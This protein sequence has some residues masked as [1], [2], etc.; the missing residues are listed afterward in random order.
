MAKLG[1][2]T[3]GGLSKY[4]SGTVGELEIS[5]KS[6][7]K[8]TH[9]GQAVVIAKTQ[10]NQDTLKQFADL[11]MKQATEK[12]AL[13][14][15]LTTNSGK[16]INFKGFEKPKAAGGNRGD[17]AE[18][19]IGAAIAARFINKNKAITP[20]LVKDV[21]RQL[22]PK[23]SANGK[24]LICDIEMVSL[25]QNPNVKDTVRFYLSLAEINMTNLLDSKNW[26]SL[27]DLI[28]SGVKYANGNTVKAWSKLLYENNQKNFIEVLSDGL[29]NQTGTKVDV[30]V[31]VDNEK[32]NINVSLKAGDV[33]QFG[34]VGGSE[35]EKQIVLWSTL[36]M[37]DV[38][39]L[40]SK[41]NK[42][43]EEKKVPQAV[44][45]T[46]EYVAKQMNAMLKVPKQKESF[47]NA[48]GSGIEYFA[49]LREENVTLVQMNKS[50][51]KVYNFK[52]VAKAIAP[53]D[54]E[55]IVKD[56]AGKPKLILQDKKK[57]ALLE[58]RVKAENKPNG[59]V[60]I[61]NYIEKGAL[62]GDLIAMYA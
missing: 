31:R 58:V 7:Q 10:Q 62:M 41:Y 38:Y 45:M 12:D 57:R 51:A 47:L 1:T 43:V 61:R 36:C 50:E 17:M 59:E 56:S 14:L 60:Y 42:L 53:L 6:A 13:A 34:Q 16:T 11:A 40:E 25:N 9:N 35:F 2:T 8:V 26:T 52:G 29:G 15:T 23:K 3:S 22:T 28:Q 18:G 5:M 19:I 32:T 21:L 37:V 24:G 30:A 27:D 20:A 49:T 4:V 44:Y 55:V 54:L 46:Y 33:K 48:L 39:S